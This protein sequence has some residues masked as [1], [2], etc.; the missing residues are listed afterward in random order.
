METGCQ[1]DQGSPRA[2]A[3]GGWM[4]GIPCSYFII[5]QLQ[6]LKM[7]NYYQHNFDIQLPVPKQFM[8]H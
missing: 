6:R 7:C 3:P 5:F 4:D 1:G 2:V 8:K